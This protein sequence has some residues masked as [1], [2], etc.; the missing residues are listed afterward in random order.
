MERKIK[1]KFNQK[2]GNGKK[3]KLSQKNL[4]KIYLRDCNKRKI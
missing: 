2:K 1:N 4:T 3:I